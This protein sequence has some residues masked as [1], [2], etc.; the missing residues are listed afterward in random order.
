MP[1][2]A[3]L[4]TL[5]IRTASLF[6][7]WLVVINVFAF[8][9][10]N[11]FNLLSDTAY[12]WMQPAE[13]FPVKR[14]DHFVDAHLR[15]DSVWYLDIARNG[16][17]YKGEGQLSNIVFFPLYPA[18]IALFGLVFGLPLAGWLIS[19]AA[20]F[21][22]VLLLTKYVHEHHPKLDPL[23]VVFFL[24]IF[25]TAFF[26]NAVYTESLFLLVT[27]AA[28]Y[29]ALKRKF[30]LAGLLGAAAALTR[31]TGVLLIVPFLIEYLVAMKKEKKKLGWD[32]LGLGLIP[33]G[34]VSFLLYHWITFGSPFLFFDVQASWGRGFEVTSKHFLTLTL[35][36]T[37]NLWLDVSFIVFAIVATVFVWR[38]LRVSYAV[39]MILGILVP[40]STGTMMSIGRYLLV[41]FPIFLLAASFKEAVVKR[42]WV[43]ISLLLLA[44]YSSLFVFNYWAG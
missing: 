36:A 42:A 20:L 17:I 26:L 32:I 21:G 33:A 30:W 39:Y 27:V 31:V 14:F 1:R 8:I 10:G 2:K 4:K 34:T 40:L 43:M 18:L 15:W 35:P 9:A 29:F 13:H 37:V 38:R 24:L 3:D 25:P 19:V 7:V 28:F 44:L 41:L 23:D 16:Y 5:Y 11:R 12:E 6:F 22:A